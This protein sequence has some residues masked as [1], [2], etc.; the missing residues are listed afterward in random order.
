MVYRNGIDALE[1]RYRALEKDLAE[2]TRERDEAARLL[3]EARERAHRDSVQADITS[4]GPER[5]RRHRIVFASI[6][7]LLALIGAGIGY[8]AA[9]HHTRR[10]EVLTRYAQ[11]TDQICACS[12]AMCARDAI[13]EFSK[14]A[15]DLQRDDEMTRELDRDAMKRAEAITDRL[16]PCITRV[17]S[18]PKTDVSDSP[19]QAEAR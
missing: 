6:L 9:K 12:D 5:R 1:A 19:A 10:D 18:I 15:Q 8:R 16:S 14:W 17:M 2:R 11:F 13:S 7:A 4:G 3:A